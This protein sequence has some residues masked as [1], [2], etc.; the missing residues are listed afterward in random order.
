M[1][2]PNGSKYWRLKYSF[3]NKEKLL[4]LGVYPGTTL[5][6]A[7]QGRDDAKKLLA[8][9]IDPVGSRKQKKRRALIDASNTFKTVALEWYEKQLQHW[10]AGYAKKVKNYLDNDLFPNLGSRPYS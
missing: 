4:A 6:E 8:A 5:A 9:G 2:H 1:I 7:R 10:S 3:L